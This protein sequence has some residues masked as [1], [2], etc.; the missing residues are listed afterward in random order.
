MPTDTTSRNYLRPEVLA[1]IGDLELRARHVVEGFVSGM[2][3]S[4]YHGYSV[5][6]A[7]YKEYV[8]GDDVRHLD[9]RVYGRSDRF[10]IKQYEEE[11][12]L[13][14][15]ILLDCSASMRYPE[16]DLEKGRM[17]K[18]EY[19]ATLAVSLAYLLVAQ[20]DAAGL[21]LF[22]NA[23]QANLPPL[24]NQGHLRSII[25]QVEQARLEKP[26]DAKAVFSDLVGQLTRRSL[27]VLISDLLADQR[28]VES[29][30][31]RLRYASHEVLVL[32]VLD[33]DELEFPFQ[34]NVLFEG[35]EAAD[36]QLLVDPQSLRRGYLDA[37]NRFTSDLRA[38]CTSKRID[39]VGLSTREPLDVALR[40][41][42]AARMRMMK[43]KA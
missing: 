19:A 29:T 41:F 5:E 9:W 18:F 40:G 11:T 31:E 20:Q 32:H 27:V 14:T 24:S 4:P 36:V 8:P 10:Y 22:D 6:F 15:H 33:Q 17:T 7:Q 38:A 34:D 25:G 43:A 39:Y 16:Q 13:R 2:H 23:V 30:L 28:E 1:R 26:T 37:L 12:N 35:I 21:V 3:R 42:L